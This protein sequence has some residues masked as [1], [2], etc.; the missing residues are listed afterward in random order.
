LARKKIFGVE[1]K[2]ADENSAV[3]KEDY[4]SFAFV[5][6]EGIGE[7]QNRKPVLLVVD[8]AQTSDDKS[9]QSGD[10]AQDFPVPDEK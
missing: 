8:P 3:N 9:D 7:W 5:S 1:F 6:R 2:F 4:C 10:S